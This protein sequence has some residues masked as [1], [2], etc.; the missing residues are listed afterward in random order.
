MESRGTYV[1]NQITFKTLT[2]R[3]NLCNYSGECIHFS[4]NITII[5]TGAVDV[6]KQAGVRNKGIIFKN[7]V[8]FTDCI[9]EISNTQIDNA[10]DT[11]VVMPVYTLIEHSN[12]YLK[13]S[14]SSWRYYRDEQ[15]NTK[16]RI[17]QIPD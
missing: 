1:S 13:T 8:P 15:A 4:G 9:S 10:K 3:S 2:I 5:V 14:K 6:A 7:F 17:I 16:F 11:D 12:N